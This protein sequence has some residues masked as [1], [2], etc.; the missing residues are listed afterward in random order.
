MSES[1][2]G[3]R[4]T[5]QY[6]SFIPTLE[7]VYPAELS[8]RYPR[9]LE[10]LELLWEQ[11]EKVRA[12]FQE[13]LVTQRETRQGFPV[14]VYMEIFALSEHYDKLHP[15]PQN[16]DDDFWSWTKLNS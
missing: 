12:Y 15:L 6:S 3:G 14:D 10:K 13:L 2:L 5:S 4:I 16:P 7:E 1:Q 8:A 11:P 9:I